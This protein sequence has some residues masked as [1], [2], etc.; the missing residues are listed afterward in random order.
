MDGW[1]GRWTDGGMD[2]QLDGWTEGQD[3]WVKLAPA[4]QTEINHRMPLN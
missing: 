1:H 4:G 2:W 3:E